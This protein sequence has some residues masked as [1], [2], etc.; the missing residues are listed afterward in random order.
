MSSEVVDKGLVQISGSAKG[1]ISRRGF[2][3]IL[4]ASSAAGVVGCASDQKQN[5]YPF[6][7][8][9][10]EQIP[11]VATWYSTTC[12]ECTAGCGMVIR[13]R[14]GRA[15]KAEGNPNSPINRGG[16]CALGQASL[17]NLYDPDRVR[18]PLKRVEGVGQTAKFQPISWDDAFAEIGQKLQDANLKAGQKRAFITG[19]MTGA[20]A[21]LRSEFAEKLRAD[22][23]TYDPLQP[24][25]LARASELAFGIYG[26]PEYAFDKAE[27]VLNFGADFLETWVSPVQFARD[28]A[29]SRKGPKPVRV[30]HVEPRLSLT[31]ANADL[32]LLNSPG[33]ELRIAQA[34]L[35][36]L[37][38]RGKGTNL[39]PDVRQ[40]LTE[41]VATTDV[42]AVA[43]EAGVSKEKLL[44]TADHLASANQ[45]LVICG[46][47]GAS[48]PNALELAVLVNLMNSVLG[49]VGNTVNLA[50][51]RKPQT[52]LTKLSALLDEMRE[53][54]V[55]AL[56]VH[57][58]N[59][60]FSLP[61]SFAF[62]YAARTVPLVVSFSS[63]LDETTRLAHYILPANTF[64]ESWGDV[65][66]YDGFF[67]LQQPAM[68]AVFDTRMLGDILIMLAMYGNKEIQG[69]AIAGTGASGVGLSGRSPAAI[70]NFLAFL[71]ESWKA[72]HRQSRAGSDFNTFW[73]EAVERGGYFPAHDGQA[74]LERPRVQVDRKLFD[75][76]FGRAAFA[77]T[78]FERGR[79]KAGTSEGKSIELTLFPYPSVKTFDGRAANRPWLQELADPIAQLVWE[80]WAELH[81]NTAK[82]LGVTQGDILTV[83]NFYGEIGVPV[84]LSNYVSEGLV[85]IPLG[86]GHSSYGRFAAKVG[87][88]NVYNL[89]AKEG[90]GT[91]DGLALVSTT[92]EVVRG[93]GRTELVSF[94]GSDSQQKRDVA[95]TTVIKDGASP[96]QLLAVRHEAPAHEHQVKQMYEQREHP[97]YEWGLSIDLAACTGCSA[98]VVACY[99]ENNIPVVG[100]E[101]ASEGR[102]MAWLRIERYYDRMGK[103][104]IVD[105]FDVP[106]DSE[107][108]SVS[109]L[110]MMCQQCN[111]APCEPVCPV[112]ATYHN[113]EGLNAMVYNRCVGTRYCSNNCPY[114]VRRFN[115]YDYELPEP[116]NWQLNPD[117]TKRTVGIMEKCTFCVQRIVEARDTAK[118]EGRF[119]RDGEVKPACVQS[120]P[121]EALAFGNLKDKQSRVSKLRQSG[122]AYKVLDYYIN[123]QPAV[124]YLERVR[125]EKA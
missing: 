70:E 76:K 15:V 74:V 90:A 48:G 95:R 105:S 51:M 25:A 109:F 2:L 36:L 52:S 111:N 87:L 9:E 68:Q 55:G 85:A 108:L 81:P 79:G 28:W 21:E 78:G 73:K 35:K 58:T 69:T 26:I 92:V 1:G 6:V 63:Q 45:S 11:G 93:R 27:V 4:G 72:V 122:R 71:Q 57:G 14:E 46:G 50:R 53:G 3:K 34:L 22:V 82:R 39:A 17:Q 107:E 117:V 41:L 10:V 64:L 94:Q 12:T 91:N 33:T 88:G 42:G 119:V 113:E 80:S 62:E 23:A 32:W 59:P 118:D 65:R 104:G 86:Q 98:C 66:P 124:S 125:Y 120:C 114:K 99:A 49:N 54:K 43:V 75:L 89:I 13:T 121:T 20:L 7:K 16:L 123:T 83:R 56:F 40:S 31:G 8:G 60:A 24:V 116:L 29:K 101:R 102:E 103:E 110:P 44:L 61:D 115:W 37:L 97:V 100:K 30:I 84:L 106:T 18:Q 96:G 38:E 47:A 112:Y 67:G 5:I 19:E 77:T